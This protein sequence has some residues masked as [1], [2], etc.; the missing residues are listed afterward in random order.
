MVFS[1]SARAANLDA[2]YVFGDSL[3]DAG[4]AYIGDG[5]TLPGPPYSNGRFSNGNVWV[6]DMATALG[7]PAAGVPSLAGGT[8]YAI[9]GATSGSGAANLGGELALYGA[10][11]PVSDPNGLYM[12]WIGANDLRA[13]LSSGADSTTAANEAKT[14]VVNI[15]SAISAL[16]ATG[17]K[18]FI[19]M[20]VP[21]LGKT[22]AAIATGPAGV[23]AAS[24][25]TAFFDQSLVASL[26]L[27]DA[28]LN[29]QVLD[30]YS[31]IDGIAA[32]PSAFGFT[33]VTDPCLTGAV[34]Y[35]GGTACANP[36]QYL[37]WDAIH[38]TAAGHQLVADAAL[39]LVPEPGSLTMMLGGVGML[40]MVVARKRRSDLVN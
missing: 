24:A 15:D 6:Q 8:D 3:S 37:F 2:L 33:D 38:P 29:L 28:G 20:T 12:I 16:K 17:A 31:L 30:T 39:A 35:S 22:P 32:N 40:A 1:S 27:V 11:H 9:G 4:N 36:N 5:G 18:N 19:I 10:S 14:A 26:P 21:D 34:N 7:L 23:A 25:L 13:I